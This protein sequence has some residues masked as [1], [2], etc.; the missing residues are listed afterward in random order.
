M[1][2]LKEENLKIDKLTIQNPNFKYTW[3]K[4][5]VAAYQNYLM[6]ID[7]VLKRVPIERLKKAIDLTK[8]LAWKYKNSSSLSNWL[9]IPANLGGRT[10]FLLFA[11]NDS[12]GRKVWA[13][14]ETGGLWYNNDVFDNE[15]SWQIV[16]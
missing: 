9:N 5:D 8:N 16:N 15:S 6:T 7:L 3:A 14:T 13:C 2:F 4:P 11:P 12:E 10:R 1:K